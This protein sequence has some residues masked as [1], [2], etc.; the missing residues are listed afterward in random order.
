MKIVTRGEKLGLPHIFAIIPFLFVLIASYVLATHSPAMAQS[1]SANL[2]SSKEVKDAKQLEHK[3][4]KPLEP[5][6]EFNRGVPRSS[7][8]G[9]LKAARDGDFERAAKYLDLRYLPGGMDK[10][11]GP[12][13]ARQLKIALDKVLWFDLEMVSDHPAGFFDDGLPANRD[14]IGRIETPEKA[15]DLRMQRV[16]RGDGL[17][18]WKFSNQTVCCLAGSVSPMVVFGT[19]WPFLY[20]LVHDRPYHFSSG[21]GASFRD[22]LDGP[23]AGRSDC[24]LVGRAAKTQPAGRRHR[25]ATTG[26]NSYPGYTGHRCRTLLAGQYRP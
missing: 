18:I 5:A 26:A 20:R 23:A 12:Q 21:S 8:K 24:F 16:P 22:D 15:V 4:V 6:D 13:L 1:S 3:K 7:L 10:S 25:P 17:Y 9:Y 19:G 11:D 2:S 14:I